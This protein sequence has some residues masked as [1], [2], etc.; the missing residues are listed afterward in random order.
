MPS[1]RRP[2]LAKLTRPRLHKAVARERLFHLIDAKREHPVVWISGPPGAGKT[3]LAASY[4]K[5]AQLPA[6]WY[7][8]DPGD[9][10]PATF[11]FYLK[12]AVEMCARRKQKPLPLLTPEYLPDL[13]GFARKFLR[14][15]FA[16]LPNESL[17]VF[18]N[19]HELTPGSG[20]H[21]ALAAAL[22]E[23]PVGPNVLVLS[24]T[25]PPSDFAAAIVSQTLTR[26]TWDD[27]KLTPEEAQAI[28]KARGI[29]DARAADE[30]YRQTDGWMA[31]LTL[32][33]ER[34]K[35]GQAMKGAARAETL[36]TLFDYFDKVLFGQATPEARNVMLRTA[37]LPYLNSSLAEAV[38][39]NENPIRHVDALY[40]RQLFITRTQ[41]D[42]DIYQ[43]HPLFRAFLVDRARAFFCKD[44]QRQIAVDGARCF[45]QQTLMEEAFTLYIE[46]EDWNA[47]E[48]LLVSKA[49]TMI[50]QGRWQTLENWYAA[51]PSER[52]TANPW[53]RYWMG[54]SKTLIDPSSAKTWLVDAHQAFRQQNDQ[55]GQ[56]L[57]AVGFA[58]R[59]VLRVQRPSCNGPVGRR[60]N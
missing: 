19:Y 32:M 33:I 44:E 40:R 11:F 5:E 41:G 56:L 25:E 18:D 23:V 6:I 2:L 7:Q 4:L 36:G 57:C 9:S 13:S 49:A 28:A 17:W 55:I 8:I 12:Q 39:S 58:A 47:A 29:A 31:G 20:V 21:A 14:D 38:T 30:L 51:L 22:T 54:R 48:R 59:L 26:I 1:Q 16:W 60:S 52:S 15:A 53:I 42:T 35:G 50:A 46:G 27:L 45:E 34:S 37:L 43:Y 24:R 3:T 10:D